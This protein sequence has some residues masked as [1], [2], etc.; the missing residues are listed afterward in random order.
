VTHRLLVQYGQPA[1]PAAFDEHYR[2]VHIP[3]A[4]K[5]PGVVGFTVGHP[6]PVGD[7][8]APYLLAELDFESEADFGASMQS[9][10]GQAA[11][12]D[13]SNFATGGASMSHF[14]VEDV[15]S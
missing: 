5:I 10:E 9:A 11:A 14:E 7:G 4:R 6:N 15:T 2:D 1:D 8:P 13:V 3:L 12:S